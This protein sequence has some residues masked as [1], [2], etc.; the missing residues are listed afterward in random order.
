MSAGG[1][2]YH[3]SPVHVTYRCRQNPSVSPLLENFHMRG[4]CCQPTGWQ[5]LSFSLLYDL[6]DIGWLLLLPILAK[7]KNSIKS[8]KCIY[9]FTCIFICIWKRRQKNFEKKS[10]NK[11]K[12]N[13]AITI[14]IYIYIYKYTCLC[15]CIGNEKKRKWKILDEIKLWCF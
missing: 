14:Y 7:K 5:D 11:N 15:V 1:P 12:T 13:S 4:R 10:K 2:S 3:D 9:K 6:I 8:V